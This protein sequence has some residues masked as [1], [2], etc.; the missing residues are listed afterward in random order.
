DEQPESLSEPSTPVSSCYSEH[1]EKSRGS[2]RSTNRNSSLGHKKAKFLDAAN[3]ALTA[4]EKPISPFEPFGK[5]VA[6]DLEH[7]DARQRIIAQKIISDVLF[8]GQNPTTYYGNQFATQPATLVSHPQNNTLYQQSTIPV[9]QPPVTQLHDTLFQQPAA[10]I[11]HPSVTQLND[12]PSQQPAIQNLIFEL[13]RFNMSNPVHHQKIIQYIMIRIRGALGYDCSASDEDTEWL[14]AD[15][16]VVSVADQH[17]DE[18]YLVPDSILAI[19]IWEIFV[20]NPMTQ[21]SDRHVIPTA[22]LLGYDGGPYFRTMLTVICGYLVAKC[23]G[24]EMEIKISVDD[25]SST[26]PL[27]ECQILQEPLAAS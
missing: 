5:S 11:S 17:H 26:S 16:G 8:Y 27:R 14:L 1:A 20:Q 6:V 21:F 9:L 12:P 2:C 23:L 18:R 10:L 15:G 22:T 4:P 25:R 3:V 13:L 19:H 24:M 7:M